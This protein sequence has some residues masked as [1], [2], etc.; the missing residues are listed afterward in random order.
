MITMGAAKL[1]MWKADEVELAGRR[2]YKYTVIG[3]ILSD[4]PLHDMEVLECQ[5]IGDNDSGVKVAETIGI[6][7][8]EIVEALAALPKRPARQQGRDANSYLMELNSQ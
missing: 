3:T 6:R 1:V 5:T 2:M 4:E 8:T 7:A